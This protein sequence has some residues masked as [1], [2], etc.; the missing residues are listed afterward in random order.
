M[1]QNNAPT[2]LLL[3]SIG[4]GLKHWV[5]AVGLLILLRQLSVVH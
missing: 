2:R 3:S 4:I 1:E 5:T